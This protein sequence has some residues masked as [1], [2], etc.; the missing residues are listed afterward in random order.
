[1]NLS[2]TDLIG[3]AGQGLLLATCLLALPPLRRLR[4]LWRVELAV[5]LVLLAALPLAGG[6]SVAQDLRGAWGDLSPTTLLLCL[7]ALPR[8]DWL[9]G[10]TPKAQDRRQHAR[11]CPPFCDER[12]TAAAATA[13]SWEETGPLSS[14]T[15]RLVLALALLG[16]LML[17]PASLATGDVDPY[18]WGFAPW[19]LLAVVGTAGLAGCSR[20]PGLSLILAVDL[21]AYALRLTGS[22]NLWDYLVDPLLVTYALFAILLAPAFRRR[23]A[24]F[25][26]RPA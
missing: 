20:Y 4:P 26:R 8:R 3:L 23:L 25:R 6:L 18:R 13:V 19:G 11:P 5:A 7:L 14:P 16:G 22:D 2:L 1:M 17:Y 12:Q 15:R 9:G 10:K 21:L 24:F